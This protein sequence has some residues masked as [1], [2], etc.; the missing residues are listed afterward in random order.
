MQLL[1]QKALKSCSQS[2][3]RKDG[4]LVRFAKDLLTI[5]IT[6]PFIIN[7]TL[8]MVGWFP[9][10]VLIRFQQMSLHSEFGNVMST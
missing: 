5:H 8:M 4:I 7:V 10:I 3:G 6:N 1:W 2:K 9:S